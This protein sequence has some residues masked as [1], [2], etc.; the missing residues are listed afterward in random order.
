M[1]DIW[2]LVFVLSPSLNPFFPPEGLRAKIVIGG[3]Q[4][5]GLTLAKAQNDQN[6]NLCI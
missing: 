5:R 3:N 1:P 6:T 4:L 2:K